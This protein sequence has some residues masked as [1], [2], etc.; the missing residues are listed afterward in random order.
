MNLLTDPPS[1]SLPFVLR[2]LRGGVAAFG[3]RRWL[4]QALVM[5]L[6]RRLGEICGQMERL[7]ARFAAG[8]LVRIGPRPPRQAIADADANAAA[9]GKRQRPTRLWPTEF[10]W[11]CR[12]AGYEAAGFGGHLRVILAHPEMVELLCAAPQA[13][14]LLRPVCRMLGVEPGM[15][16]PLPASGTT[17]H[18]TPRQLPAAEVAPALVVPELVVP[19][20]VVTRRE[21][22]DASVEDGTV[23]SGT[24]ESGPVEAGPVGRRRATRPDLGRIPLPRGV[25]S[26]ARRQRFST[27]I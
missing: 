27:D 25:L 3:G 12:A 18:I 19:E 21:A 9:W 24:V 17:D 1:L 20:L 10:G 14:R 2:A 5:L 13:L 16:R 8:R 22:G 4:E 15:L 7:M 11:L 26:L 23:E 6:Y